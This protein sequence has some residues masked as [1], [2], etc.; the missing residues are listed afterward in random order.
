MNEP[1]RVVFHELHTTD[2]PKAIKFWAQMMNWEI[3]EVPMGPGEP[4]GLVFKDGHR[5][6][7]ITKS[8]APVFVPSHWLPYVGV[9]EVDASAKK[10]SELGARILVKPTDVPDLGRFSA[11]ADPVGAGA[12]FC[13]V[14]LASPPPPDVER[15]PLETF[16]WDELLTPDPSAATTFYAGLFGLTTQE[17]EMPMLG[18][19]IQLK[20]GERS[21]AG[22][23]GLPPGVP[24]PSW[25]PYVHVGDVDA[26][27]EKAKGLGAKIMAPPMD[28]AG[29]GR[30][31]VM[32]DPTGAPIGLFKGAG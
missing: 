22:I 26:A 28:V 29:I 9:A 2:R 23:T 1:G 15:A 4:Y 13:V 6:A 17:S 14:A 30:F 24:R 16:C 32:I 8:K 11:I 25:L 19:Y 12:V 31:G 10:A 18:K 5:I 3:R 21:R 7:G 27:A 20:D